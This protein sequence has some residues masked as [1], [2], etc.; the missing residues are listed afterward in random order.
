MNFLNLESNVYYFFSCF[1][2]TLTSPRK[3]LTPNRLGLHNAAST[4]QRV[5][6]NKL[7]V[8]NFSSPVIDL[9]D[10]KPPNGMFRRDS[11]HDSGSD[12]EFDEP[13]FNFEDESNDAEELYADAL[14][15]E[16][17]KLQVLSICH[18]SSF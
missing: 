13:F 6:K 15:D 5:D 16:L 9:A 18:L 3:S 1:L 12:T 8:N 11:F 7:T 10:E 14:M 2:Q 4:P 17:K